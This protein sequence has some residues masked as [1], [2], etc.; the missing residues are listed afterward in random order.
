MAEGPQL[1]NEAVASAGD[2]AIGV[3]AGLATIMGGALVYGKAKQELTEDRDWE[4]DEEY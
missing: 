3:G 2:V 4:M 1:A